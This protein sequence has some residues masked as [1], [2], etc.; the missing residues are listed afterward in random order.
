MFNVKTV[1]LKL[2]RS[3]CL[4]YVICFFRL[5]MTICVCSNSSHVQILYILQNTIKLISEITEI[6]LFWLLNKSIQQSWKME[7]IPICMELGLY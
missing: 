7:N 3:D 5:D 1:K 6:L 4:Q 2:Y